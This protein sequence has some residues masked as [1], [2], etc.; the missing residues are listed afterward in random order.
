MSDSIQG[1][2][3]KITNTV[4][5][6]VYVGQTTEEK[7]ETR[8]SKHLSILKKNKH[9]NKHL[10]SAWNKYGETAFTF[11]VIEQFDSEVNFDL[12]NLER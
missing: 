10:Q 4:N 9:K 5:G 8:W 2:I 1:W 12:S 7:A 6:K 3:Y 11:E